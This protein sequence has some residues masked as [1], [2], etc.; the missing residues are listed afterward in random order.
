MLL[1]STS[2]LLQAWLVLLEQNRI[3]S[4]LFALSNVGSL[5]A[6][7]LYPTV[8]EPYITLRAPRALWGYGF[9]R[10]VALAVVLAPGV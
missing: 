4:R 5:L 2:P 7:A 8:I 9:V 1:G 3:P 10:F 6:L